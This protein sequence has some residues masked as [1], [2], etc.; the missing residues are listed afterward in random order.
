MVTK[1]GSYLF[2]SLIRPDLTLRLT[3]LSDVCLFI[4]SLRIYTADILS[5][6]LFDVLSLFVMFMTI[7]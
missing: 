4:K 2:L 6:N 3:L 7:M 5:S 1:N